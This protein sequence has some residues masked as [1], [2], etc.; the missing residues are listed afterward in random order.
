M[1]KAT[2]PIRGSAFKS[3]F[4]SMRSSGT[5]DTKRM[6]LNTRRRRAM[7]TVSLFSTGIKLAITITKSKIFQPERKKFR[8][9]G[10]ANMRII[11]STKKKTVT[12]KSRRFSK[13]L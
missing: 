8:K 6:T 9:R 5:I 10:S 13:V 12:A 3:A 2:Y 1:N 11:I 4:M 7:S